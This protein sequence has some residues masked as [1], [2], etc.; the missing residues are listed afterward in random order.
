MI[1]K[2]ILLVLAAL[3]LALP[4]EALELD[5]IFEGKIG[6][7]EDIDC[8][9]EVF[10]PKGTR[11]VYPG[12]TYYI[13]EQ[14]SGRVFSG[15]TCYI[16]ANAVYNALFGDV[17]YHGESDTW[18]RS[19]KLHGYA[20]SVSYSSFLSWGV[21][22]GSLMR[23]TPEKDG[24]Y[25]GGIGH[26]LIIIEF[27]SGS[28]TYLEGNGDGRGLI[29]TAT[30]S[31]AEFNRRFFTGKGYVLSFIVCPVKTELT[32][33]YK[34]IREYGGFSD[35]SETS[36]Y[37]AEIRETY[38]LGLVSGT[39]GG[40]MTPDGALTWAQAVTLTARAISAYWGDNESFSGGVKWYEPY[41]SYLEKWGVKLTRDN[42]GEMIT[43][44]ELAG[45]IYR[46]FPKN[47]LERI[48]E[49]ASFS[50]IQENLAIDSLYEAGIIGGYGGLFRPEDSLKRSE[51]AAIFARLADRAKRLG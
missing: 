29:R 22:P 24:S 14:S 13:K 40:K 1:K 47:E 49:N 12:K 31:W 18:Q 19:M 23:T 21:V 50:D 5:G 51:T 37:Y 28:I 43:R 46:Y 36:W 7:Y 10:A 26:S 44:A 39:G 38:E 11:T 3:I 34:R 17:P 20:P 27:D 42:C 2:L 45:L 15:T 4:A 32:G 41:Y 33:A 6:L 30:V 25:N 48:R 8:T 9:K 35:V 16:Y